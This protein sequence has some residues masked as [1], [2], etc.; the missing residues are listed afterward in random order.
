M[1]QK[2]I[3]SYPELVEF[4]LKHAGVAIVKFY[5]MSFSDYL[6]TPSLASLFSLTSKTMPKNLKS[7]SLASK[8]KRMMK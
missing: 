8:P 7:Q 4:T 6:V 3:N 2:E 1:I 5:N